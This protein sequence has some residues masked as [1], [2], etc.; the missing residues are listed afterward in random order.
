MSFDPRK[1]HNQGIQ[2]QDNS[3]TDLPKTSVDAGNADNA[4]NPDN[5]TIISHDE[6]FAQLSKLEDTFANLPA[7]KGLLKESSGGRTTL[8]EKIKFIEFAGAK[9]NEQLTSQNGGNGKNDYNSLAA[10]IEDSVSIIEKQL[11]ISNNANLNDSEAV[12]STNDTNCNIIN[13]SNDQGNNQKF[14]QSEFSSTIDNGQFFD[15]RARIL[16]IGRFQESTIRALQQQLNDLLNAENT[17]AETMRELLRNVAENLENQM[18]MSMEDPAVNETMTELTSIAFDPNSDI[19]NLRA[20]LKK[21]LEVQQKSQT[22][23]VQ[24]QKRVQNLEDRI[25]VEIDALPGQLEEPSITDDDISLADAKSNTS[26]IAF[27]GLRD[28]K[29][30]FSGRSSSRPRLNF[31]SSG[32][33]GS[34][35]LSGA[36]SSSPIKAH[37]KRVIDFD[38]DSEIDSFALREA[39]H[40]ELEERYH[41]QL[42]QL[43]EEMKSPGMSSHEILRKHPEITDQF[44]DLKSKILVQQDTISNLKKDKEIILKLKEEIAEKDAKIKELEDGGA[45]YAKDCP[46]AKKQMKT[47]NLLM[48]KLTQAKNKIVFH[49]EQM[50]NMRQQV[51]EKEKAS[52]NLE[53]ELSNVKHDLD[54]IHNAFDSSIFEANGQKNIEIQKQGLRNIVSKLT[55]T[56]KLCQKQQQQIMS[57]KTMMRNMKKQIDSQSPTQTK[58][59]PKYHYADNDSSENSEENQTQNQDTNPNQNQTQNN[60]NMKLKQN[61]RNGNRINIENNKENNQNESSFEIINDTE[62]ETENSQI[63][64]DNEKVNFKH[65]SNSMIN[66]SFDDN[67]SLKRKTSLQIQ[68]SHTFVTSNVFERLNKE[69]FVAKQHCESLE[70]VVSNLKQAFEEKDEEHLNN[71]IVHLKKSLKNMKTVL[72]KTSEISNQEGS[73]SAM[74]SITTDGIL[75]NSSNIVNG[76]A[77]NNEE[78]SRMVDEYTEELSKIRYQ[79]M[80]LERQLNSLKLENES[81]QKSQDLAAQQTTE[82]GRLKKSLKGVQEALDHKIIE[83][84]AEKEKL[85]TIIKTSNERIRAQEIDKQEMRNISLEQTTRISSLE[86]QLS[87]LQFDADSR[88]A[89]LTKKLSDQHKEFQSF[90]SFEKDIRNQTSTDKQKIEELSSLLQ[91]ANNTISTLSAEKDSLMQIMYN[92]S[93]CSYPEVSD[94]Q[95][96]SG[97]QLHLDMLETQISNQINN[98]MGVK[99]S[100]MEETPRTPM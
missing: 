81:L 34:S 57:L 29:S 8:L 55:Q 99:S 45:T 88:I 95:N 84:Q 68:N 1:S 27:G 76:T 89:S 70:K 39:Y 100:I 47:I 44:I 35:T 73:K 40:P 14:Q 19:E 91:V 31:P 56:E 52:K 86:K 59:K 97:F 54:I 36:N 10:V 98:V 16:R 20:S 13:E 26:S 42:I 23:I 58:E 62:T 17:S 49:H 32:L 5:L 12:N 65:D 85:E 18:V 24:L 77:S 9:M 37:K 28:F 72:E 69:L 60:E 21:S 2:P 83:S 46:E 92:D 80:N 93:N 48:V 82:I 67:S 74:N 22:K 78:T 38:D 61:V 11:N 64:D 4:E 71:E 53:I 43:Q 15:I 50:R 30:T 79:C 41:D 6:L 66:S 33:G 94:S 96:G 7:M 75:P 90:I 3:L 25:R 63:C 87:D 51:A